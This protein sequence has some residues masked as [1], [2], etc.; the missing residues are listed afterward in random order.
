M[1][2]ATHIIAVRHGETDWNIATRL[3]GHQ[4]IAL[5]AN[6]RL[7]AQQLAQALACETISTIYASDL[8]RAWDTACAVA[9]AT[10]ATLKAEAGLRERCFGMFEGHTQAEIQ[11]RWP[12]QAQHWHLREP[13]WAPVA[14]ESLAQLRQRVVQTAH[15]L[16]ARHG[17]EQIVWVTHGGV[18]DILYRHATGQDLQTPR[19]W[20]LG[21]ASI[22]RLR[23]TSAQGL[24]LVAWSDSRHLQ[25]KALDETNS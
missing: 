5:N 17:G 2:T 21:N 25:Q 1:P 10:T 7:Q 9:Q 20:D 6:G 14:G 12:E 19:H 3:Q 4:D 15:A 18:L 13:N 22:N 11:K 23:W 16:A 24:S 8:S